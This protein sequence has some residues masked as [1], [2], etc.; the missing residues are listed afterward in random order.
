MEKTKSVKVSTNYHGVTTYK[1][2]YED[3]EGN[4][5]IEI[6]KVDDLG[7]IINKEVL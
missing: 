1:D 3:E 4:T 5:E 2:Y 6:V 7:R